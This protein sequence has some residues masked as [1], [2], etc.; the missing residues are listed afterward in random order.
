MNALHLHSLPS[1]PT[2]SAGTISRRDD[3]VAALV[4]AA[5]AGDTHAWD[6]IVQRFSGTIRAVTR[7]FRLS[8]AEAEDVTQ[9]VWLR[10]LRSIDG[11]DDPGALKAWLVT[12]ARRETL[13][14]LQGC[15]REV[16][17]DQPILEDHPDPT[18]L[19]DQVAEAERARALR[20]ALDELP[21]RARALL[22]MLVNQPDCS[23]DEVSAELGI[24]VGSIGPTR[25]RS[26]QRL[27]TNP[28]LISVVA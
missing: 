9:A 27:R 5:R 11:L 22:E 21:T 8:A 17:T 16:P 12:T 19:D 6:A 1:R 13:R 14:S 24:P 28:R 4:R 2:R 7:G 25:G 20:T 23:Y 3:S 26:L 18:M 10:L 15:A